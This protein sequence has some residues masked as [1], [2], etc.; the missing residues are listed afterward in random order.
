[1]CGMCVCGVSVDGGMGVWMGVGE[2]IYS[3]RRVWGGAKVIPEN[4]LIK[5]RK[6]RYLKR[7]V[8]SNVN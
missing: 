7:W 6:S 3:T 2:L 4:P 1:M 5:R 8:I